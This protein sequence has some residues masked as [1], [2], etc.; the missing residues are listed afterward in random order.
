MGAEVGIAAADNVQAVG[1]EFGVDMAADAF[2]D[3]AV[4]DEMVERGFGLRGLLGVV[5]A[6]D[7]VFEDVVHVDT[8]PCA[9]GDVE[10]Q[11]PVEVFEHL[12]AVVA[13]GGQVD[14]GVAVAAEAVETEQ[15]L[16]QGLDLYAFCVLLEVVGEGCGVGYAD[17]A[18]GTASVESGFEVAQGDMFVI[19]GQPGFDVV[20]LEAGRL[21]IVDL[22]AGFDIGGV[23]VVEKFRVGV[24]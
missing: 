12:L 7:A 16:Q 19:G 5:F 4:E 6:D 10:G 23:G 9:F 13:F 15:V 8:V 1:K 3:F 11:H 2:V 21:D 14:D 20:Q 17:A 22:D 18:L 24:V